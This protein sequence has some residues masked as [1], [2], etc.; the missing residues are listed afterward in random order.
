MEASKLGSYF[1]EFE[2]DEIIYHSL[3]KTL[4]VNVQQ[5]KW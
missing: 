1:E 4:D 5:R 2:K 3:S